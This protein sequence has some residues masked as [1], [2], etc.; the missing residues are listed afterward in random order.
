MTSISTNELKNGLKVLID[1]DPMII[2]KNEF[3]K[4]GKGQAFNRVKMR[5]LK[6]NRV[7]EKTFKS[8]ETIILADINE[9]S[10]IYSYFN[11]ELYF[12]LNTETFDEY[13]LNKITVSSNKVWLKEEYIYS[14]TLFN[15]KVLNITPPNF[16]NL[17]IKDT[18]PGIKGDTNR[19]AEKLA[20][21]ETGIIVKV[22]LFIEIGDLIRVDT[23]TK[24]YVSRFK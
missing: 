3:I 16:I 7:I 6:N 1:H 11:G 9:I 8:G 21:L 22:P 2:I 5:N 18:E 20:T 4:P 15:G 10:A 23:R 14:I 17:L 12:F 24:K 19:V 13:A